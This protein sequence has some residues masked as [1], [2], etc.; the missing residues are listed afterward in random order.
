MAAGSGVLF[1]QRAT[2]IVFLWALFATMSLVF[3]LGYEYHANYS[4]K[5][6]DIVPRVRKAGE[7]AVAQQR[8]PN[9]RQ[10]DDDDNAVIHQSIHQD[11]KQ[12]EIAP[13]R[14]QQPLRVCKDGKPFERLIYIKTHKTG[15]STL[16]NIFHRFGVKHNLKMAL[17]KDNI[18]Y[19]WPH[20][21]PA[22]IVNSVDTTNMNIP[23][24][25][26]LAS[27]HVRYVPSALESMVPNGKY[28]TILRNPL[29]HFA[30]SWVHWHV[31]EHIEQQGGPK[32]SPIEFLRNMD[33][34]G[35]YLKTTDR[36]LV[37]NSYTYDM[38]VDKPTPSKMQQLIKEMEAKFP[39]VLITE[40][41]DESLL[42]LK[43]TLCWELSD[44]VYLSLKVTSHRAKAVAHEAEDLIEERNERLRKINW[45]DLQLYQHFNKTLFERIAVEDGFDE[46]LAE[47]K[48]QVKWWSMKCHEFDKWDEDAHRV[49]IEEK[50]ISA[51]MKQC[52]YMWLDSKGFVKHLKR[53]AGHSPEDLE[54]WATFPARKVAN[55][56]MDNDA[57]DVVINM[58]AQWSASAGA[59]MMAV[60]DEVLMAKREQG[61]IYEPPQSVFRTPTSFMYAIP[62]MKYDR[63]Y[64]DSFTPNLIFITTFRHPVQEFLEAWTKLGMTQRIQ[65]A[66]N[67]KTLGLVDFLKRPKHYLKLL[68]KPDFDVHY[69]L[70]DRTA[71]RFGLPYPRPTLAD[72]AYMMKHLWW[73]ALIL[74]AE[75]P[76][77]SMVMLRRTLCWKIDNVALY[78]QERWSKSTAYKLSDHVTDTMTEA[79]MEHAIL[80]LNP[81]D[82]RIYRRA[83]ETLWGKIA[84]QVSF[85]EE[86]DQFRAKRQAWHD[87][88]QAKSN[89]DTK[90][91][92]AE[93]TTKRERC[94]I[95]TLDRLDTFEY[96]RHRRGNTLTEQSLP[97]RKS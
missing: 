5:H 4:M 73:F 67:D 58:M 24:F 6:E 53:K 45:A 46:E 95:R 83:N 92:S 75:H 28:V 18:F 23:P 1:S 44:I 31:W 37:M 39:V 78:D 96:L 71:R 69:H 49:Q 76:D 70:L 59:G 66:A 52:H 32:L 90:G 35:H 11:N 87:Y 7:S 74:V 47:L 51:D 2:I 86:L 94:Y 65:T 77:E 60:D 57:D 22:R 64:M 29:T 21:S 54:C 3:M 8:S 33:K 20:G 25:H 42:L 97:P 38:G 27:A 79:E 17:P 34:Y 50:D 82:H 9:R 14:R 80:L 89:A 85:Q 93:E 15:S 72:D 36:V 88:C 84:R 19:A 30:S 16:T 43:R 40:H 91:L 12:N 13:S 56:V 48:A 81:Y 63:P 41:M 61:L 26:I 10:N 62:G 55:L 68:S